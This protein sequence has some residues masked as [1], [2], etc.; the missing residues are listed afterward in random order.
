MR[1]HRPHGR[2][3]SLRRGPRPLRPGRR[4]ARFVRVL[5]PRGQRA[6]RRRAAGVRVPV[7]H[8]L[9]G[10]GQGAG[11]AARPVVRR[12]SDGPARGARHVRQAVG[13]RVRVDGHG[14]AAVVS[15]ARRRPH[16]V[17]EASND[18]CQLGPDGGKTRAGLSKY[19][20]GRWRTPAAARTD[21]RGKFSLHVRTKLPT[22][23]GE[24][25][26]VGIIY[27]AG[28]NASGRALGSSFRV[29]KRFQYFP[30]HQGFKPDRAS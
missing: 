10:A 13:K 3:R 29:R 18:V 8:G 14:R 1:P 26:S 7:A 23:Y 12:S 11:R 4:R 24:T 21:T 15:R 25:F 22:G 28:E 9:V 19:G 6:G 20:L 16:Q 2:G 30:G 17:P 27:Q 5:V